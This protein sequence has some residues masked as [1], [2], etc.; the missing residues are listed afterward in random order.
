MG[1]QNG[2]LDLHKP[3]KGDSWPEKSP[4]TIPHI[5]VVTPCA[6][7]FHDGDAVIARPF[8]SQNR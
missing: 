8:R 6:S 7:C 5:A 1:A 4:T 3:L 2:K